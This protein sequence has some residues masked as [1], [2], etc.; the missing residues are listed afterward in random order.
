MKVI[1]L[2]DVKNQGKKGE[3]VTV[4]DAYAR[5][6]LFAKNQ[7]VE[8][9]NKNLND[10]KLQNAHEQKVAEENYENACKLAEEK[11]AACD[12]TCFRVVFDLA[13]TGL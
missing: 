1:L 6:V 7:A 13:V 3:V 5:N 9:T 8:A 10:L 4:S 11:T 2:T 12:Y